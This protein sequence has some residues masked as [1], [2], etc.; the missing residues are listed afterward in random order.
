VVQQERAD[1]SAVRTPAADQG[2]ES[3][4][5]RDADRAAEGAVTALWARRGAA[6]F[7]GRARTSLRSGLRLQRCNRTPA[8]TSPTVDRI[9]VVDGPTGAI[10]GFPDILGNADLNS[11]GPF[12]DSATGE[13]KNVHQIHFHLDAG[14]SGGLTPRRFVTTTA[15]AAGTTVLSN[16]DHDDGPPDHEIRRPSTDRIVVADAPGPRSLD[17]SHYPFVMTSDFVLTVR[18]GGTDIAR[19]RYG[20]RINKASATDIPNTANR[21]FSTQKRDLVRNRDLP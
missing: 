3:L 13:C 4:L 12:N 8:P 1:A 16:T 9:T 17:A 10:G 6:A 19:I 11:P 20:V 15:T 2:S 7:A 5:E 18:A 21:I 14:D